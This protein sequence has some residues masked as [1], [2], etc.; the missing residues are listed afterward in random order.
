MSKKIFVKQPN[1]QL[2]NGGYLVVVT[3]K[4]KEEVPVCN[5]R[6][7]EAQLEAKWI[8]SMTDVASK[9]DFTKCDG[10]TKKELVDK[11]INETAKLITGKKTEYLKLPDQNIT[12]ITI[13]LR[14]EA[15]NF[16]ENKKEIELVDEINNFMQ[17]FNIIKEFEEFGLYFDEGICKLDKIYTIE[18]IVNAFKQLKDIGFFHV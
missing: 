8:I 9:E 18:D 7:I 2:V 16:I 13:A 14:H 1:L 5:E 6:F 4:E 17:Q 10:P 12:P 3:G 15:L 11:I